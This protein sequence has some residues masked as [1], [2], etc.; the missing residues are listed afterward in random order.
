MCYVEKH[1]VAFTFVLLRCCQISRSAISVR[2]NTQP[3][4]YSIGRIF[5]SPRNERTAAKRTSSSEPRSGSTRVSL[6]RSRSARD[7]IDDPIAPKRFCNPNH[8]P[9]TYMQSLSMQ[10]VVHVRLFTHV[11]TMFVH[12]VIGTLRISIMIGHISNLFAAGHTT[13]CPIP[14]LQK[15]AV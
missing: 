8:T 11:C 10:Y 15:K 5:V 3:R 13:L 4:K 14:P 7:P 1:E 2:N 9:E 6:R 12:Y